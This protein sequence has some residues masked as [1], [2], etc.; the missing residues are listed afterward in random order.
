MNSS[1]SWRLFFTDES[2]EKIV[3]GEEL[4]VL[5]IENVALIIII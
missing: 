1:S 5:N 4:V 3:T 2:L